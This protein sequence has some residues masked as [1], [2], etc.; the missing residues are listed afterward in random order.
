MGHIC[1]FSPGLPLSFVAGETT[2]V[3]GTFELRSGAFVLKLTNYQVKQQTDTVATS[4]FKRTS[5]V[6][7]HAKIHPKVQVKAFHGGDFISEI[8]LLSQ[9][10][11]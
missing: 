1:L 2:D 6:S 4:P 9:N 8:K 7:P 11:P 3:S 10:A 5:V